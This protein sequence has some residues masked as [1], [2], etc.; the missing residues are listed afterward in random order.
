MQ[1]EGGRFLKYGFHNEE[2]QDYKFYD[3]HHYSQFLHA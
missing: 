1:G 3:F 2:E